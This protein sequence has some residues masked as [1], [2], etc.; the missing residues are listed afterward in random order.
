MRAGLASLLDWRVESAVVGR[1]R[2]PESP[3]GPGKEPRIRKTVSG[4]NRTSRS[5]DS[6]SVAASRSCGRLLVSVQRWCLPPTDCPAAILPENSRLNRAASPFSLQLTA[7]FT[8]APMLASSAAVKLLQREGGR[9]PGAFVEVRLIAEAE[10]RVPRFELV[11]ALKED[12]TG[13]APARQ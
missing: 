7:F 3:G 13:P 8:S 6:E 12:S 5:D 4:P 9:P 1:A 10:R 2:A 11:R